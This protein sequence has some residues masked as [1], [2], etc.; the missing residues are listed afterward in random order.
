MKRT[1]AHC[2][3]LLACGEANT[4][5]RGPSA[6]DRETAKATKPAADG[7]EI[8][9]VEP[10]AWLARLKGKFAIKLVLKGKFTCLIPS[11]PGTM[12]SQPCLTEEGAEG[13]TF[14]SAADCPGIGEGPGLYCRFDPLRRTSTTGAAEPTSLL[15]DPLPIRALF[16]I[17]P[18]TRK[19]SVMTMNVAS[20]VLSATGSLKGDVA[21]FDGTCN[22]A[23]SKNMPPCKWTLQID[24]SPD[25]RSVVM[26]RTMS[27]S[28]YT[29]ELTRVD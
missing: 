12:Q 19:I 24:A 8:Q 9:Q 18:A 21:T 16:G 17:D 1:L 7:P 3:V 5:P 28:T 23:L 11:G 27:G 13:V 14:T 6:R 25:G 26:K 15:N 10:E 4:A 22:S 2:V 20:V 29:L